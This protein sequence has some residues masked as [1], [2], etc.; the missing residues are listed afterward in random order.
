MNIYNGDTILGDVEPGIQYALT[1]PK[2]L[3]LVSEARY[4]IEITKLEY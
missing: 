4:V 1:G 3:C 2:I